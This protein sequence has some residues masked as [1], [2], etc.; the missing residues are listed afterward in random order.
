[1]R[2]F[3][4][5]LLFSI[6]S[7]Q[8]KYS[9][10]APKLNLS[11]AELIEKICDLKN[12]DMEKL[13]VAEDKNSQ[14]LISRY[15][16]YLEEMNLSIEDLELIHFALKE[17]IAENLFARVNLE[18]QMNSASILEF[19]ESKGLE[20]LDQER[21]ILLKEISDKSGYSTSIEKTLARFNSFMERLPLTTLQR[22]EIVQ[23]Q[24]SALGAS[25][26][27]AHRETELPELQKIH[28]LLTSSAYSKNLE[29]WSKFQENQFHKTFDELEKML[30]S[31]SNPNK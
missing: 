29:F 6:F 10:S 24:K 16:K 3:I 13:K 4:F 26:Y 2:L 7:C 11:K 8:K 31:E 1:M 20:N 14:D 25:L 23:K 18:M 22:E 30:P 17:K 27:Y 5:C 12:S 21:T 19:V 28:F 15:R 9:F